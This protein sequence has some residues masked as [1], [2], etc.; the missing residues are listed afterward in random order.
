MIAGAL[1]LA[2][3][4]ALVIS[5][6]SQYGF[7]HHARDAYP[8]YRL[9][10]RL[11]S[12]TENISHLQTQ[13]DRYLFRMT[14]SRDELYDDGHHE[15]NNVALQVYGDH[16]V[17]QGLVRAATCIYD[18]KQGLVI[19]KNQVVATAWDNI[20]LKTERLTY[21]QYTGVIQTDQP[22]QF[23]QRHLRGE[24]IGAEVRTR[25]GQEQLILR[26]QVRVA[27][28]PE[29]PPGAAFPPALIQIQ[30]HSAYAMKTDS[31]IHLVGGVSLSQATET[32]MADRMAA[33]FDSQDKLQKMR[34]EGRALMQSHSESRTSEVRADAMEFSFDQKQ[35]LQRAVAFGDA[36]AKVV[37]P[38]QV[39]QVRA[40]R[41]EAEF[42]PSSS[43]GSSVSRLIGDHGRVEVRFSPA[44]DSGKT[45]DQ[46]RSLLSRAASD[47]KTLMAD[48][49]ELSYRKDG[50]ELDRAMASGQATLVLV[51]G[52]ISRGA[53][54]KT[55]HADRMDIEFY[56]DGNLAKAFT[57]TGQVRVEFEPL[58]PSSG[59]QKRVTTSQKLVAQIDRTTQ[60]FTQ[61]T[62]SGD[63]RFTE[64]D[65]QAHSETALYDA[66]THIISLRGGEPVIW[67]AQG[68]TRAQ[69]VDINMETGESMAH[70]DVNTTYYNQEATNHAVP[71]QKHQSPVF[72]AANQ[73]EVKHGVNVAIYTGKV[74]AW[75]ED[76]YV[77]ADRMELYG[78]ERMM[79]AVG[80]VKSGF[81]QATGRSSEK[82]SSQPIPVF[83]SAQRMTY[84]DAERLVRY[85]AEA[86]LQQGSDRL[87]ANRVT[88]FLKPD[89]NEI[90]RAVAEGQVVI[91]E[92]G[93]R[94]YG[95][96]AVYTAADARVVLIGQPARVE[97]DRY[98]VTQRGPRL[99][100]L[101]GDDK[102]VVGDNGGSQRIRSV[103]KI[104]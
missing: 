88:V 89:R 26:Q 68:R 35:R 21:D 47:E 63:F 14:A 86:Q 15:L 17:P 52:Q 41:I 57:A 54:R 76:N 97:D 90:D 58:D 19:F 94:A 95:D 49:V 8:E 6:R 3:A 78:K 4:A 80:Q 93:R 92:P 11:V 71:F 34:A 40:P 75:Q 62:Q 10:N 28:E 100:Y 32:L 2:L 29:Q 56:D 30:S 51:P 46:D 48:W 103:R 50:R 37:E 61:L 43:S 91:I 12:V 64:G 59:K 18:Q 96:Q 84:L 83:A 23:E 22:V 99:T 42:A 13:G 60:E 102:V 38:R 67:D 74:R 65:R 33:V 82:R 87:A 104:Q 70:G 24:V 5:Y 44:G 39:R 72:V 73:A 79:V 81:Y 98:D 1:F 31:T 16:G 9:S 7:I 25:P 55:I 66:D 36:A 27:I 53:E 69:Q 45:D 20:L 85:E 77:T 101:L